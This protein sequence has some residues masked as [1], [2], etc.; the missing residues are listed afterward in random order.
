MPLRRID[1]E[2]HPKPIEKAIKARVILTLNHQMNGLN[3]L[4]GQISFPKSLKEKAKI[5]MI[6]PWLEI[7][8]LT[9]VILSFMDWNRP[10]NMKSSSSLE[11]EKAGQMLQTSFVLI[12][13]LKVNVNSLLWFTNQTVIIYLRIVLNFWITSNLSYFRLQ[14]LGTTLST[15]GIF[16]RIQLRTHF[17]FSYSSSTCH[18]VDIN[19]QVF[20]WLSV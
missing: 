17:V 12:Q 11:T 8:F 2:E 3:H 20:I 1:P 6:T 15:P 9:P 10:L 14:P 5:Q 16:F 4:N 19:E 7:R 13:D 18:L